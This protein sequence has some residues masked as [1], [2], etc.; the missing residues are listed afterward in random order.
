MHGPI[1]PNLLSYMIRNKYCI[2]G[3]GGGGGGGS[4]GGGGG[5]GDMDMLYNQRHNNQGRN[6]CIAH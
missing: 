3:G 1:I 6:P 2:F 5:Y 4:G